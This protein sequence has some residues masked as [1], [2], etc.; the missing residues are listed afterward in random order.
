MDLRYYNNQGY[1]MKYKIKLLLLTLPLV[2]MVSCGSSSPIKEDPMGEAGNEQNSS[3][4]VPPKADDNTTSYI[5]PCLKKACPDESQFTSIPT[6]NISK[7]AYLHPYADTLSNATVTRITDRA[8]QSGNAHPYS[9]QQAWNS[10]MTL[11]RLGYRLYDAKTFEESDVIGKRLVN[12]N[13]SGLTSEM[14]WSHK[15]PNTYYGMTN[16]YSDFR[17]VRIKIKDGSLTHKELITFPRDIYDELYMGKYEGN[18]DHEDRYVVF[19]GRKKGK[20]FVT[21]I[22]YDIKNNTQITKELKNIPW[23]MEDADGNFVVSSAQ[24]NQNFD[25]ISISPLGKNILLSWAEEPNNANSSIRASIYQYDNQMKFVRK[26]ADHASHG[27]IGLDA[28][29]KEVFVQFGFGYDREGTYNGGIWL[30]PLDGK[31]RTQLLPSKYNGG[32]IG[33]RN[34]KRKGWCYLSAHKK[35]YREVLGIKLD[36]SGIVSRFAQTHDSDNH[37]SLVGVSP[38]GTEIIFRSD[39]GTEGATEET[40]HAKMP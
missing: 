29:D 10:D 35:G 24:S 8:T 34:Y 40:Y 20:N 16:R 12:Y 19:A 27:D 38:D 2:L 23:Y 33:C 31:P 4:E 11:I 1:Q 30:Y 39:W 15:D 18:I 36:G 22:V 3:I 37:S 5:D 25:W 9:K 26:L 14:R 32:H 13:I 21:A 7:P 28:N 6:V 17:F